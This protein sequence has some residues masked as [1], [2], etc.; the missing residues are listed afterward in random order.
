MDKRQDDFLTSLVEGIAH[1]SV[2]RLSKRQLRHLHGADR[3]GKNT[4]RDLVDRLPSP[5]TAKDIYVIDEDDDIYL[6]RGSSAQ[7]LKDWI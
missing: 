2:I 7:E 3:L 4:W 5:L 6:I 1:T